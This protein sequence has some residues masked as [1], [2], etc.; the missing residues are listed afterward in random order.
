MESGLRH[1]LITLFAVVA[2]AL[3]PFAHTAHAQQ[4]I[5]NLP[6]AD[7]TRPGKHFLMNETFLDGRGFS[8]VNFYCYG[9]K[10][11]TELALTVYDL[12]SPKKDSLAAAA[13][14]KSQRDLGSSATMTD[15]KLTH[16]IMLPFN[17]VGRG[18]GAFGYVHASARV[19]RSKTRITTGV[20]GGTDHLFGSDEIC[21]L[22]GIEQ[23]LTRELN[24]VAEWFSGDHELGNL[25]TGLVFHNYENDLI[26]VGA[27]KFPNETDGSRGVI[28]E[29][30]R[31]F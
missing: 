29:L 20:G 14:F 27:Y 28:L 5:I 2:S 26:V 25:T 17:L 21:F 22:G 3:H 1:P 11:G 15:L 24:V 30:G 9:I 18:L 8:T 4:A 7:V 12:G 16:G 13:G 10:P 23:P 31:I 19:G 6:S